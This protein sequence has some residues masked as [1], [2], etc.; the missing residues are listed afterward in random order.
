MF[1]IEGKFGNCE[2]YLHNFCFGKTVAAQCCTHCMI[3]SAKYS[4]GMM[5][6]HRWSGYVSEDWDGFLKGKNQDSNAVP[7]FTNSN[8]IFHR[9][10]ILGRLG[11]PTWDERATVQVT[12]MASALARNLGKDE[13]ETWRKTI[14]RL[15]ILLMKGNATLLSGRIPASG[16]AFYEA[17]ID[18]TR[19]STCTKCDCIHDCSSS[20]AP[21]IISF[22]ECSCV[23]PLSDT[24]A[25]SGSTRG[26]S[27][28][29]Q[30]AM[31]HIHFSAGPDSM[32][33]ST[34][35]RVSCITS[36]T[37]HSPNRMAFGSSLAFVTKSWGR[38]VGMLSRWVITTPFSPFCRC[39]HHPG[40][41][42]GVQA[43]HCWGCSGSGGK[44]VEVGEAT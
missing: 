40:N 12:K 35:T 37:W 41:A 30:F 20:L 29:I 26:K 19:I 39:P 9:G 24:R 25:L 18:W 3:T 34:S 15:W 44:S 2:D 32:F 11:I 5:C 22:N 7:L 13:G 42:E 23:P 21:I 6:P 36:P 31:W 33:T 28:Y 17:G 8:Y 43:S 27:R 10:W 16:D 4:V 1:L 38:Q 14:T